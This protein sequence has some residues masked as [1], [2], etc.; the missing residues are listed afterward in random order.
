VLFNSSSGSRRSR[1]EQVPSCCVRLH[2]RS[3]NGGELARIDLRA[4]RWLLIADD[5][6]LRNAWKL[7]NRLDE[8]VVEACR[9]GGMDLSVIGIVGIIL[10]IGI[11][12]KN[13]IMLVD[14]AISAGAIAACRRWQQFVKPVC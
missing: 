7:R 12:K 11:V 8:E 2:Q 5:E 9:Q 10:L 1:V 3:T 6:S 14:F 13:G 4:N